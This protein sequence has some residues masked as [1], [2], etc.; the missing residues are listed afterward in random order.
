MGKVGGG[1]HIL[2]SLRQ[3]LWILTF[4]QPKITVYSLLLYLGFKF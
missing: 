1:G 3:N 4:F 2:K